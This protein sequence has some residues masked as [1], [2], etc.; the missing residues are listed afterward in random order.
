M[1]VDLCAET[2]GGERGRWLRDNAATFGWE[3]P[4]WARKGGSGYYEPWHWEYL[5]GRD[6]IE[7]AGLA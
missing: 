6:A 3:N 2:Y 7:A 4:A 1:A 5:P